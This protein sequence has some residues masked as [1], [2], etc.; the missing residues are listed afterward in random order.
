MAQFF[1]SLSDRQ[2]AFIE[3]QKM[4]FVATAAAGGRINLSPKGMDALRVLGPQRVAWLNLTGSGNETAAHVQHE[5]R[6]TM[7]FC[8]FEGSP[9]IMRLFGRARAVHRGDADWKALIER[10]PPLPGARQVFELSI[11]Q[12]QTSCGFGVPLFDY[13]GERDMLV[14]WA[15]RKGEAGIRQY[16]AEKNRVSIDG[17]ETGIVEKNG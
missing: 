9:T 6:M 15:E 16:W 4:F 3:A 12:V 14:N 7:M 1:D 2:V 17:I 13:R 5:P 11:D 8:A 10:F